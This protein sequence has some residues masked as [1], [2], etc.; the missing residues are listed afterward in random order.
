M[1]VKVRIGKLV[2][3]NASARNDA[4]VANAL[5]QDL[6][7]VLTLHRHVASGKTP[8][9]QQLANQISYAMKNR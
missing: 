1:K 5:G 3:E 6:K 8:E 7:Q 2:L 9:P 4:R